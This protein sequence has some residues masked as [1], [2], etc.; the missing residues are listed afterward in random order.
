M[1]E[2]KN[3]PKHWQKN[4]FG[5]IGEIV[6][7]GTPSTK[8]SEYWNG[9]ISWI[10]P[11][12]LSGY[13]EK[14][15]LKGRKSISE[16]GL[17]NS[18]SRLIPKGSVLFSSRA[19][20]G[21]VAIAGNEVCTNQGFKSIVPNKSIFSDYLFYFL[22]ASK[23]EAEKVASGTT[24]KEISLKAFSQ[25]E[26]PVPPFSEQ[27]AIVSKIEELL[28]D[29]D[30]GKQQLQTAQQQLKV[31]R[32]SLLKW[33][34]AG[35][36]TNKNVKEGE[37]PTGW[38]LMSMGELI[39]KP[40]YGTSKKCDYKTDGVGVLRIPNI[41]QGY[42]DSTDLKF[43]KFDD[44]EI[45]AYRLKVGDILIIRSNGSVDL[46]GKSALINESQERYLYAGYL[47]KLRPKQNLALPK[48][49]LHVLS[50]S[51]LRNQ[52]EGKAKS[53]SGVNNINSEELKSL[54][55][56]LCSIEEQ[57]LIV[58]ELESKL[59]VCDKI[60]ETISQSLLQA[61]TLRQSILKKAFEGKLVSLN[62]DSD[63][64]LDKHEIAIA[65]EEKVSYKKSS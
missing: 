59:T 51:V 34:F 22:K 64:E 12:D 31:Y 57:Q 13:N 38:K 23:Q 44:A 62:Y 6:S 41:S 37:L 65:A 9:N 20:I 33:A 42:I 36:L 29:L 49:L 32:Q 40:Q 28:S 19:P 27:E 3:I 39:E 46:V 35:K 26:I 25:L 48:Y 60:E 18:S 58:N 10:S 61:E 56:P 45:E 47:I 7:G 15:I 43:A 24:F 1:S 5:E 53:T 63:D 4:K 21:Y 17:K 8:V 16:R 52:I 54:I 11:A 50:S 2:V 55:I 14:I 30:N